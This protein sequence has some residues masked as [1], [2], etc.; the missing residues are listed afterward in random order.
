MKRW[1]WLQ[2][3]V[4]LA[5][6]EEQLAEHGGGAGVRDP[7]LLDSA[8]AR[9]RNAAG[10]GKPDAAQLAAAY[11]FGLTRNH[12]FIDGNKRTGYVALELFLE[13]NGHPLVAGDEEAVVTMLAVAAGEMSEEQLATWIR[14]HITTH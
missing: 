8:L 13:L 6:H 14:A 4:V 9:P 11:A 3:E 7:G 10:D 12:P 5:I 1:V 2:H